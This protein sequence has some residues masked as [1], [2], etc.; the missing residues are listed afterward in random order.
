M[1]R[2]EVKSIGE[3]ILKNLRAQ[4]LE[5]PLQ[6][7]ER[8]ADES[9]A[10]GRPLVDE[11]GDC[12]ETERRRGQ[13]SDCRYP[14]LLNHPIHCYIMGI[15]RHFDYL[16]EVEADTDGRASESSQEAVIVAF[17]PT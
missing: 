17:A 14:F 13:S 8:T 6:D 11:T 7:T 1:F 5:T 16:L 12:E 2:K 15:N 4:G 9:C 3:L 10:A